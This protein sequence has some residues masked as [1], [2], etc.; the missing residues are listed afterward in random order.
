MMLLSINFFLVSIALFL[1][2][3]LVYKAAINWTWELFFVD[4][5]HTFLVG[6]L[7]MLFISFMNNH[8]FKSRNKNNTESI[9][10]NHKDQQSQLIKIETQIKS[11]TFHFSIN[12]FLFAKSVGNYTEI[13]LQQQK[14]VKVLKRIPLKELALNLVEYKNI[15]RS[16]RSYIVNLNH[17]K[18]MSGNAQAYKL[19]FLNCPESVPVSRSYAQFFKESL[20]DS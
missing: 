6:S 5:V 2:R 12:E 19:H 16:H 13:Y 4:I 9:D 3:E 11:E 10:Q 20:V 1:S 15:V 18:N 8:L 14:V 17:I 7:I